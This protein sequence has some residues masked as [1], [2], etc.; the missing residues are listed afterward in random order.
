[1]PCWAAAIAI[2]VAAP[3]AASS[4][5]DEPARLHQL[6]YQATSWPHPRRVVAK[7]EIT[8]LGSNVR[9]VVTNRAEAAAEVFVSAGTQNSPVVG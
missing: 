1:M 4:W 8:S 3:S 5:A 7:I 9:F 2:A 6:Q